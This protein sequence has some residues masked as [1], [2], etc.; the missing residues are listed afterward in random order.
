MFKRRP[1]RIPAHAAYRLTICTSQ[2][3][4]H[5][6]VVDCPLYQQRIVPFMHMI[7][8]PGARLSIVGGITADNIIQPAQ[9]TLVNYIL[10]GNNRRLKTVILGDCHLDICSCNCPVN[11]MDI[12]Q[13]IRIR[14]VSQV[15]DPF[16]RG[17]AHE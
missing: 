15:G 10:H 2:I 8:P 1:F 12:S 6:K 11:C 9:L 5:V 14:R 16:G 13:I 17:S 3:A 4:Q 7:H